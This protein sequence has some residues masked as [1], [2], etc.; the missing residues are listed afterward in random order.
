MG[1]DDDP[2][3]IAPAIAP[4]IHIDD[5]AEDRP[6]FVRYLIRQTEKVGRPDGLAADLRPM[7]RTPPRP[8]AS[9]QMQSRCS[10]RQEDLRST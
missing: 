7:S 5:D 4:H 6:H 1:R 9:P 10:S 3:V 8:F 2:Q